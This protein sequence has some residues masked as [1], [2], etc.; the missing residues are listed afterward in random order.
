MTPATDQHP[1]LALPF[2][3][4]NTCTSRYLFGTTPVLGVTFFEAR[5]V[6]FPLAR[7]AFSS[8]AVAY[9]RDMN[10][11]ILETKGGLAPAA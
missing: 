3:R 5:T 9:Q 10:K 8:S 2:S 4:A 6:G 1:Y 11:V 7:A